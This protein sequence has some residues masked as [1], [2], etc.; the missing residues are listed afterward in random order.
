MDVPAFKEHTAV[1]SILLSAYVMV[2][3]KS[4]RELSNNGMR[5]QTPCKGFF[6]KDIT[7]D[8]MLYKVAPIPHRS[9]AHS[10]VSFGGLV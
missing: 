2:L 5:I 3:T 6:E 9:R 10:E 4:M 8:E 7:L 1:F